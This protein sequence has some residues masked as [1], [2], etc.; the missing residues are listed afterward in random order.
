MHPYA[1]RTPTAWRNLSRGGDLGRLRCSLCCPLVGAHHGHLLIHQDR[2]RC[3][4]LR[5]RREGHPEVSST[6]GTRPCPQT[7]QGSRRSGDLNGKNACC[8]LSFRG[9][10]VWSFVEASRKPE[11]QKA[12]ATK[13]GQEKAL[14]GKAEAS[15]KS[16]P[17]KTR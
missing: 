5:R 13:A 2:R 10:G 14:A 4:P 11:D 8:G 6:P 12:A 3:P 7:A 16:S 1:G 9:T 17:P 15:N